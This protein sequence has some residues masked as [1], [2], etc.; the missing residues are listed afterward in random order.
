MTEVKVPV[1]V[2]CIAA[3]DIPAVPKTNMAMSG[4]VHN[5]AAGAA[6]D[7]YALEAYAAKADALLK[8]CASKLTTPPKERP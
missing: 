6:A 5:K 3:A 4:D 1:A 8:Q 2:P 7:V